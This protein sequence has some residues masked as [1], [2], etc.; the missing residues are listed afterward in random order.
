MSSCQFSPRKKSS[1]TVTYFWQWKSLL[2]LLIINNIVRKLHR[3]KVF[4]KSF[5]KNIFYHVMWIYFHSS[6]DG[7]LVFYFAY[8]S[9]FHVYN[10]FQ[11]WC[12]LWK[13]TNICGFFFKINLIIQKMFKVQVVTVRWQFSALFLFESRA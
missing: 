2:L 5:I 4:F 6:K 11:G 8:W 9:I 10:I 13:I 3:H 12:W 1:E 7:L